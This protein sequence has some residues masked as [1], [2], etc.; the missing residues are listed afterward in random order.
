M[1]LSTRDRLHIMEL[2]ARYSFAIDH[3]M[4]V[5]WAGCFTDD[6]VM[7]SGNS[8]RVEGRAAF[9]E[10]MRKAREGG[11]QVRPGVVQRILDHL[12]R[13]APEPA[14]SVARAHKRPTDQRTQSF[15]LLTT[16]SPTSHSAVGGQARPHLPSH[17]AIAS[18]GSA[19]AP[20]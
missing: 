7:I 2:A 17:C 11:R 8:N 4:G 12:G 6:G 15:P 14:P 10:H 5:E 9:L 16:R 3:R 13:W 18:R 19:L 20:S 1:P